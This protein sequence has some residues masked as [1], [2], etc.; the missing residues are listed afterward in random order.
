[1]EKK[2]KMNQQPPLLRPTPTPV[3]SNPQGGL[4]GSGA[5]SEMVL[6][7]AAGNAG[8][9]GGDSWSVTGSKAC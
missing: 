1:M 9:F 6:C 5:G 8:G 4:V 2:D 7:R 3:I